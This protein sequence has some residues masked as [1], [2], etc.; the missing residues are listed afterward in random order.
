MLGKFKNEICSKYN[1]YEKVICFCYDYDVFEFNQN[2]PINRAKMKKDFKIVGADKIIEVVA[3]N[4]IEDFFLYDLEGIK[5]YLK[6][7]KA[8]KISIKKLGLET[9]KK[10]FEDANRIYFKGESVEGLVKELDKKLI[11][12][13]I[14]FKIQILRDELGCKCSYKKCKE[15]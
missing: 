14:C 1:G 13:K 6:L 10:M 15:K 8:Y 12:S 2:P 11:L 5:K 3:E 9:I 4:T 7:P